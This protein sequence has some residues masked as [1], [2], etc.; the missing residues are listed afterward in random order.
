[1]RRN[2]ARPVWSGGKDRGFE[3]R[4]LPITIGS[5]EPYELREQTHAEAPWKDACGDL[6][7]G[8]RCQTVI[9]KSSIGECY[10]S[11]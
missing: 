4:V 7:V 5:W 9:P 3:T 11:L 1:M 2:G 8:E 6:P 10:G